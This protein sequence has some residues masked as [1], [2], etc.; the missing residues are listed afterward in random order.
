M[1][2]IVIRYRVRK[3]GKDAIKKVYYYEKKSEFEHWHPK[4]HNRYTKAGYSVLGLEL[5]NINP[6]MW[7]PI[8][9]KSNEMPDGHWEGK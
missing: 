6:T 4:H 9:L 5:I 3:D 1:Y 2:K 8:Y 7:T